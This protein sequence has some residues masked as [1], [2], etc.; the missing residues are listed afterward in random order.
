MKPMA[1]PIEPTP[2]LRGKDAERLLTDTQRV[3]SP[4]EAQ[5]RV[6]EAKRLRAELMRPKGNQG[7]LLSPV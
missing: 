7:T 2:T 1:R 4:E 6:A 3:C 5:R